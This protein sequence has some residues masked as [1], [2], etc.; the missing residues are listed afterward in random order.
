MEGLSHQVDLL[1][2][3]T[4]PVAV[5]L[6]GAHVGAG[7][8]WSSKPGQHVFHELDAAVPEQLQATYIAF[9]GRQF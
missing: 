4:T 1:T 3:E 5:T 6:A 9:F 7:G 8:C 2:G